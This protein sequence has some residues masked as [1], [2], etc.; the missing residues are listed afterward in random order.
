MTRARFAF[1]LGLVALAFAASAQ[2]AP[3]QNYIVQLADPA[4]ASYEGG[5]AGLAATKPA[6]GQRLMAT[7]SDVQAYV[8]YLDN[9]AS[10]VAATVPSAQIYQRYG[11]VFNGFAASLT[12]AE[13]AKLRS[14]PSVKAITV[15]QAM[16][17]DTS[18]TP[19]FLGISNA[20]G[21]WSR[22][23]ANGRALKGEGVIVAMVDTGVW[24][25]APSFSD[26]VD[27][28]G[29]PVP[30]HMAGTVVYDALPNG[31]YLG[32]CQVAP[33][34]T[35]AHCNNKLV[36]A[37]HFMAG[38]T[39]SG[40]TLWGNEYASARD[41][42]GHGSHT[43]STAAGNQNSEG[44]VTGTVIPS[45]SGM[46]PR[47]RVA[48]Y[49]V[50]YSDN[51]AGARR[52]SC[53]SSDSIA[54]INKAVADGV[55]VINFSISGSTTS[56]LD[57]VEQAFKGASHA[58]VFVA[59]SAG[60]SGPTSSPIST[61]AHISPWISTVGNSTHDRYM[62]APVTLIGVPG[63]GYVAMGP[64]F[65]VAGVPA[66]QLILSTDAALLP[67]A[68][69]TAAQLTQLKQ[70]FGAA[71]GTMAYLDPVKVTGKILVCYRGGNAFVNKANNAKTAGAVAYI[72]QNISGT[73]GNTPAST[74]TLFMVAAAIP[75][76]HLANVHEAQVFA[77][78][79][80]GSFASFGGGTQ[81]AGVVAPIMAGSS[82]RGPN[83]GDANV[84][85]PD[86]TAPGTDIIAVYA[87]QTLTVAQR[88]A[89]IAGTLTPPTVANMISG[90]SMSSPHIAGIGALMKQ[91]NPTWSPSAIKSAIMTS[92]A[93]NV[94]L[95][96]GTPDVGIPVP[97]STNLNTGP[98]GY[99][100]GH[101][102]PNAALDTTLVYEI[103]NAQ[104]EAYQA[105]TISSWELNLPSITRANVFGVGTFTRTLTNRGS[106]T[107]TYTSSATV[108]GWTLTTSPA[109]LTIAPGASASYTATLTRTTATVE[110]WAYG[111]L[112]WTGDGGKV[113]RSPVQVKGSLFVGLS[114][115]TDTRNIGTKVYTVGTG[116]AGPM[117]TTGTGLVAA[118]RSSGVS[119]LGQPDVCFPFTVPTG[120]QVL[121]VQ[122]FNADTQGGAASD[123]D[124]I[125]RRG[126]TVIGSSGG[127]ESNELVQL[128]SNA[129][130]GITAGAHSA[131]VNAWAPLNGSANFVLSTWMVGPAVGTQSLRAFGPAQ[132][133]MGGV[134]YIG[135]AWNVPAGQRY[136]GNVQ[137]RQTA[138]GTPMGNTVVFIDNTAAVPTSTDAPVLI[139]KPEPAE[140]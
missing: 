20:G 40:R 71:D 78:A 108:P 135:L 124:L 61:V 138:G 119:V 103:S 58:G 93:Q 52:N 30:S 74:N 57:G 12:D 42:D 70:C 17:P 3:R 59:A 99:G 64:S 32:S 136:L 25:E 86:I 68:S 45:M 137:Y 125:V 35:T 120:V 47:A 134:A 90:T 13:L 8:S 18:Y 105:R 92:A 128:S 97:T 65:Q 85:K 63:N 66:A 81:V 19:A 54:A 110:T 117:L 4:A 80:A 6:A 83:A 109:S 60:N 112:L 133:Y 23:D 89:I 114:N 22:N 88:N 87:D 96:N 84:L 102:A 116:F 75:M 24:P 48:A 28:N 62:E 76:V 127:F 50:C 132:A 106:N 121:R 72:A 43:L 36:G 139:I 53:F 33:G 14:D 113:V 41:S 49:K 55:D 131:C 31:R 51:N 77:H 5:I 111:Q 82:S 98:F 7:A 16:T 1:G 11:I 21:F 100:A 122:L 130:A 94:K 44:N 126:T 79:A 15:D 95:A 67:L 27:G 38:W 10:A 46:A 2:Q 123:I 9:K 118:T 34:I 69:Y 115:V 39:S 29:K 37:Q 140:E 26:K 73:A 104:Y 101:V 107:V 56:F 129:A 91:A